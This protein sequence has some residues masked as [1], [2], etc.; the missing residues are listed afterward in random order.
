VDDVASESDA[1]GRGL[2]SFGSL[3]GQSLARTIHPQRIRSF[4]VHIEIDYAV[5]VIASSGS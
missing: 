5:D 1:A 4:G 3:L 2:P